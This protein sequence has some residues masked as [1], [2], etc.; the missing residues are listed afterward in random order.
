MPPRRK[1]SG[2]PTSNTRSQSTLSFGAKSRVTKPSVGPAS[3]K[4]S[5]PKP[6]SVKKILVPQ[7]S[8][9]ETEDAAAGDDAIAADVAGPRISEIAIHERVKREEEE[10]ATPKTDEEIRA[11]KVKDAQIKRYWKNL[12]MERLAPRV[13]QKQLGMIEKIL[14]HFDL[15]SQYGEQKKEN[16]KAERA[17]VDALMS[18]GNVN[19]V[20]S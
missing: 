17:Y 3:L 2:G 8:E 1:A 5:K 11:E 9:V 19:E 16:V 12:E 18:S 13:H 6:I 4:K 14:R 15:S 10:V 7:A 20:E